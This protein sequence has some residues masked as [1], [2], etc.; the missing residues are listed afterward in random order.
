MKIENYPIVKVLFP[1][2]LGIVVAYFG[3]FPDSVCRALWWI[4]AASFLFAAVL[5]FVKAYRWRVV[6]TAVMSA[7]FV[8]V[9]IVLTDR[10]YHPKVPEETMLANTDWL[11]RVAAEPTPRE[12]QQFFWA[13]LTPEPPR[14]LLPA[15]REFWKR[16]AAANKKF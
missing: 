1:Y 7:A 6:Q 8:L 4:S 11:V 9:G 5:T 12:H 15:D 10:H 14:E 2:V 13:D 3:D 16:L